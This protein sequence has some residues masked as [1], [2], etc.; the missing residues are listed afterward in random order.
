[1]L[2]EKTLSKQPS[3]P[4]GNSHSTSAA[5]PH[6]PAEPLPLTEHEEVV[7]LRAENVQLRGRVKELERLL[8]ADNERRE[9]TWAEQQKEYEMLLEEKSD[10]IRSQHQQLQQLR[11]QQTNSQGAA[12][13]AVADSENEALRQELL[14][15]Q[16]EL[17]EQRRQIDED[18]RAVRDQA[19]QMEIA[20]SKERVEIARQRGELQRMH[21]ELQHV[22]EQ[23]Q[24]DGGLRERLLAMQRRSQS[25]PT[26]SHDNGAAPSAPRRAQPTQTNPPVADAADRPQRPNSSFLRRLFG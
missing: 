20:M 2:A 5:T 1:M 4:G 6:G 13:P 17:E 16:E 8:Q 3:R 23:A 9:N 14:A 21:Q 18:E 12:K 22:I 25:E 26:Q 10:V 24:R 15:I 19:R 7:V 11:G